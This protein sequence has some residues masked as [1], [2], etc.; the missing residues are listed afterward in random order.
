MQ[1][2]LFTNELNLPESWELFC[3]QKAGII[4]KDGTVG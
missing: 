2:N 4:K 3:Q 1:S